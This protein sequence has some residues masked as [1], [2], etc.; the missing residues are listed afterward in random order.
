MLKALTITTVVGILTFALYAYI[1]W[2]ILGQFFSD[3]AHL[4]TLFL[5]L[6]WL[7]PMIAFMSGISLVSFML[8]CHT[9]K[10]IQLMQEKFNRTI[11]GIL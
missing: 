5:F 8:V 2:S 4:A 1:Q 11:A 6:G 7:I 3:K 10:C 9:I